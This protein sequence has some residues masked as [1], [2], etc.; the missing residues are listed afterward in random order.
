MRSGEGRLS[1]SALEMKDEP[2]ASAQPTRSEPTTTFV[3]VTHGA[4]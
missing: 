4:K 1:L 3:F 2:R